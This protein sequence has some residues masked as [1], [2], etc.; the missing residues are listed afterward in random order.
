MGYSPWG[1]SDTTERLT[2]THTH[3]HTQ[4]KGRNGVY[5]ITIRDRSGCKMNWN[6][7]KLRKVIWL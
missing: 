6:P 1:R 7:S 4:E 5:F 3:T 2:H